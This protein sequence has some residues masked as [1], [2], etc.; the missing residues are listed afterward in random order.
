[1]EL[2]KDGDGVY[3]ELSLRESSDMHDTLFNYLTLTKDRIELS[4][5]R[6]FAKSLKSMLREV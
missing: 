1:M 5:T 2:Y 4:N 3:I 6:N